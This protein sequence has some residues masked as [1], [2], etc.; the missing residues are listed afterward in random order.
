[1]IKVLGSKERN[2]RLVI[3]LNLGVFKFSQVHAGSSF[4]I[5]HTDALCLILN[6]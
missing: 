6:E 3:S 1:M 4:S 5:R 2:K